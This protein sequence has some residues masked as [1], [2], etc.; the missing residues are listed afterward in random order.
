[1]L[2]PL[3]ALSRRLAEATSEGEI[4]A[5]LALAIQ[6]LFPGRLFAIRLVDPRTLALTT[7]YARGALHSHARE[8]L[9]LRRRAVART[10][11]SAAAL[12]AGGVALV[13][14]DVPL[15]AASDR[16]NVV[17]L[18]TAGQLLG[19]VHLEYGPGS[20]GDPHEDGALL[21]QL[22]NEAAVGVRAVRSL[23]EVT[24]LKTDLENLIQHAGALI[25]AV[26]RGGA[27]TVWNGALAALTG[28]ARAAACGAPL[29]ER[30]APGERARLAAALGGCWAGRPADGMPLRLLRADGSEAPVTFNF[31]PI[32]SAGGEVE[33]ILGVGQ[34][35]GPLRSA[36]AAAEHAERLAGIGRLVA[37]VVHELANPLTAVTMYAESL[38]DKA[39]RAGQAGD[40]DRLR[41]I[42]EGGQRIQ[43]LAR[44]LLAYA[45]PG[46]GS[47]EPVD[48]GS[49]L[50]E[51]LRMAKPVLKESG[52][53]VE[54]VPGT[55]RVSANR[56]GLV[57]VVLALVTNAAQAVPPGGH[58][59]V[60]IE[61]VAGAA[62][63][64]VAD[65]GAGMTPEI[66]ARAFE[67]FFTTRGSMGIGLGLPIVKEIVE[68]LGGR[69]EL[70]SDL[71]RGT[72][73]VITLPQA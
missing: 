71:G 55:A 51:G 40:A 29:A 6:E 4:T 63:L 69:V 46:G 39:A 32:R 41:A 25:L 19:M 36:Q 3:L 65:D 56:P 5:A 26:D 70:G 49:A 66:R 30:V 1:V 10:G 16:A 37:G 50:D 62:R 2:V 57:Q 13:D 27:V 72:R 33:T 64:V 48:L 20:P 52:A 28:A 12:A 18:V 21:K 11:L 58:V 22:V 73:V 61:D 23:A 38:L 42:L 17:P 67:P 9:A 60:V 31:A 34:D 35:L 45:R 53:I 14:R 24:R 54:R 47:V 59:R 68:R 15:F 44:D 43:R 8:R 7:L